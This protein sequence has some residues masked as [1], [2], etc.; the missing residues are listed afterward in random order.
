MSKGFISEAGLEHIR[1]YPRYLKACLFR[2][3][4]AQLKPEVEEQRER[5][6]ASWW[7]R[8]T[9]LNKASGMDAI[10]E[11]RWL[12]EEFHLSIFAQQL[13]TRQKVSEK[14]LE[15]QFE[16]ITEAERKAVR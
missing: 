3:E 6:W 15:K 14:R 2:I 7:Q 12:I 16:A 11:L 13:G 1:Q 8:F 10:S 9:E 4:Q 5:L